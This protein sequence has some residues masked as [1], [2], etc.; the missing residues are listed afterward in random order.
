MHADSCENAKKKSKTSFTRSPL[1]SSLI[2]KEVT[3]AAV[4]RGSRGR[5][6]GGKFPSI[7][8]PEKKKKKK[9]AR[10]FWL[11]PTSIPYLAPAIYTSSSSDY[12][13]RLGRRSAAFRQR[14]RRSR[15]DQI[16]RSR[17]LRCFGFGGGRPKII[18]PHAAKNLM[19]LHRPR[20][21]LPISPDDDDEEGDQTIG[22]GAARRGAAVASA[23]VANRAD[24]SERSR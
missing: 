14:K 19:H 4:G 22:G 3:G 18:S 10:C 17:S 20:V 1:R 9:N 5:G 2:A 6:K 21:K 24:P 15:P 12:F 13:I 16:P 11:E 23:L 7:A 8:T